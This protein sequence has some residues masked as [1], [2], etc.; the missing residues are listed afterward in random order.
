M[1][2]YGE[3][4]AARDFVLPRLDFGVEEFLD[5]PALQAHQVIVMA[6]LVQFEYRLAGL[7]VLARQ[8]SGLLELRQH[9]V[10]GGEADVDALAD[11][12]AVDVFGGEMADLARLEQLENLAPRQ[13]GLEPDVLE[14]LRGIHGRRRTEGF[15]YHIAIP[16]C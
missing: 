8:Q 9:P 13:G 5:P 1:P 16:P 6:A 11:Q 2:V 7:E 12:R 4:L 15:G 14:A 10:N 3:S